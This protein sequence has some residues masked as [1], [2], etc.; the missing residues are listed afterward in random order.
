MCE[1]PSCS[2]LFGIFRVFA[3]VPCKWI[4]PTS[5]DWRNVWQ[6]L[7]IA[8][9]NREYRLNPVFEAIGKLVLSL[10]FVLHFVFTL[11]LLLNNLQHLVFGV[12]CLVV[13]FTGF[14]KNTAELICLW[15]KRCKRS[16]A[17][18]PSTELAETENHDNS[19]EGRIDV[20]EEHDD[21]AGVESGS[22]DHSIELL[23]NALEENLVVY[24]AIVCSI[25]RFVHGEVY[26]FNSEWSDY[27]TV[28]LLCSGIVI[29]IVF[30]KVKQ[31]IL[32]YRNWTALCNDYQR[33]KSNNC[34]VKVF[35]L[36]PRFVFH[37]LTLPLC[38]WLH[39]LVLGYRLRFEHKTL[40][41]EY[42]LTWRSAYMISAGIFL[43][44]LSAVVLFLINQAWVIGVAI[45]ILAQATGQTLGVVS[46]TMADITNAACLK[47]FYGSFWKIGSGLILTCWLIT[48]ELYLTCLYSLWP[49][50]NSISLLTFSGS[51]VSVFI[52]T[53]FACYC[54]SNIHAVVA[55]SIMQIVIN[56][57]FIYVYLA[58]FVWMMSLVVWFCI[59]LCIGMVQEMQKPLIIR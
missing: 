52:L 45:E 11:V 44:F 7:K 38:Q 24:L 19:T 29:D 12:V 8:A 16:V 40:H 37:L 47:K 46:V 36:L 21:T 43:P 33:L 50:G 48:S 27:S 4:Q 1:P 3:V 34:Y 17:I 59:N 26:E 23:K 10:F 13:S 58:F 56:I 54:I 42:A 55:A 2:C 41:L 14:V 51:H 30:F 22:A 35:G 25:V 28:F 32:V 6:A 57:L 49:F 20:V 5:D 18:Q 53:L 9:R 39:L 31:M 15:R